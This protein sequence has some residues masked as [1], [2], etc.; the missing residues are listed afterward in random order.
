ML[1]TT[2][3]LLDLQPLYSP[4]QPCLLEKHLLALL[5]FLAPPWQNSRLQITRIINLQYAVGHPQLSGIPFVS[6]LCLACYLG[7][8]NEIMLSEFAVAPKVRSEPGCAC[9]IYAL[10]MCE[11]KARI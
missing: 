4:L 1:F 8:C 2:L 3:I 11:C 9:M 10:V 7:H 6:K 5:D